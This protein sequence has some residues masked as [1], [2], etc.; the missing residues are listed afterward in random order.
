MSNVSHTPQDPVTRAP[1]SRSGTTDRLRRTATSFA[2]RVLGRRLSEGL[3]AGFIRWL[4]WRTGGRGLVRRLPGGEVIRV[5]PAH[6]HAAWN[7][8]EYQAFRASLRP[9]DVALDV[10][11]NVGVYTLLFAQWVGPT[12]HVHSFEPAPDTFAALGDHVRLNGLGRVV[13]AVHAAVADAPGTVTFLVDNPH[14]MNRL[15]A[16]SEVSG[17][18]TVAVPCETIDGYCERHGLRPGLIK[19]DVEGFELAVLRGARRTIRAGGDRLAVFMEIHPSVWGELGVSRDELVAELAAQGL[20]AEPLRAGDPV[21]TVEGLC[22]R[23]R[24]TAGGGAG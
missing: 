14:G 10:G 15:A 18:R 1:S 2:R 4:D 24:Q 22:L 23:L 11:A 7:V 13:T 6:R 8:T 16:R 17:R 3:K 19:I 9:G 5:V 20:T 12:G 21:W